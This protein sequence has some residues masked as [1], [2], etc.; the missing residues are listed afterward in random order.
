MLSVDQLPAYFVVFPATYIHAVPWLVA[1]KV[2]RVGDRMLAGETKRQVFGLTM[3]QTHL[4]VFK[5]SPKVQFKV[6]LIVFHTQNPMKNL[7][8]TLRFLL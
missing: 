7:K 1:I 6:Y 3:P 2:D 5:M 4:L 8:F